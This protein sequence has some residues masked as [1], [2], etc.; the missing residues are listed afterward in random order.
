MSILN[1]LNTKQR[2]AAQVINGPLLILAGAGSGK[3]RTVTYRIAHM[4]NEREISPYHILAV[5]FTNKAAK[6]MKE[7]VEGLIGEDAGKV[8][9]STFHSFGVRLLR[10]YSSAI[11]YDSNFNIYDADDQV[12][13]VKRILKELTVKTDMTPRMIVSKISKLKENGESPAD[14]E[15]KSG[16]FFE[17]NKLIAEVYRKYQAELKG[18]NSMDFSDLLIYTDK[19][20]DNVE[21]LEKIQD[22]Y[23]YVMVDEYQDTNHIQYNIIKKIAMKYRNLCVVGDEDQSIYGFRGADIKNILD[24]EKDYEEAAVI[25][26]EQNYR[27]TANILNAANSVIKNN[28]TSKGK[29]LWTEKK[30]GALIKLYEAK[31]AYDEATMICLKIINAHNKGIKYKEQTILYRTNAQSRIFEEIFLQQNIPYKIFG[32]MQFYQRKEVKDV[33]AYLALINNPSDD[34]SLLRVINVPNRKIG[35]RTVEKLRALQNEKQFSLL[36]TLKEVD[37]IS[38]LRSTTKVSIL[39]FYKLVKDL[40]EEAEFEHLAVSELLDILLERTNFIESLDEE[41]RVENVEELRN[42]IYEQENSSEDFLSLSSYL[43]NVS[44]VSATDDLDENNDYVKLMTIHNSKGLEF[45]YV[46]LAGMEEEIFPGAKVAFDEKEL[47]EERRLCYVAITRAEQKLFIT[48]AVERSMYG[49]TDYFRVR[50]R[51]LDEIPSNYL[52]YINKKSNEAEKKTEK[53]VKTGIENFNPF[54][55]KAASN[56]IYKLGE[57]V[58]HKKFGPGIVKEIEENKRVV[59][60]FPSGEKKIALAIAEKVIKKLD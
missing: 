21:I 14:F 9:V 16:G 40:K 27:S 44:L 29:N 53:K 30:E 22:R 26:L 28:T 41:G 60:K 37:S 25:K 51:F 34:H 24:F 58:E 19:L 12:R 55:M 8:L 33:L 45:P 10:M 11:G 23:R 57:K 35:D 46:Y 38:G 13:I 1:Q 7:R 48:H 42:S 54:K 56:S 47:E 2:E 59:I 6:E 32:G 49:K 18:N 3:T 43:E 4:I 20:L 5:T 17:N 36:E 52:E 31:N 50:S 15:K 39:N